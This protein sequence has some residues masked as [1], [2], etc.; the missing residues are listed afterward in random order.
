[1]LMVVTFET[2]FARG[3]GFPDDNLISQHVALI[4]IKQNWKLTPGFTHRLRVGVCCGQLAVSMMLALKAIFPIY[5]L[6]C[7]W[8]CFYDVLYLPTYLLIY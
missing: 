7:W 2:L 1:M 3:F 4:S 8:W 5:R 6:L